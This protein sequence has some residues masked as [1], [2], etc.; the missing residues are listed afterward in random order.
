MRPQQQEQVRRAQVSQV[1]GAPP[2]EPWT[3]RRHAP[4]GVRPVRR[5]RM[6]PQSQSRA[7]VV[8]AAVVPRVAVLVVLAAVVPRVAVLVVLAV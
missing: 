4:A 6:P 7:L 1:R 2:Q 8:L 5:L 3:T